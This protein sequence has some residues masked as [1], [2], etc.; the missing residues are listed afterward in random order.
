MQG[1]LLAVLLFVHKQN[2][3]ANTFL[4]LLVG[5]LSLDLLQEVFY[6]NRLY[7]TYPHLMGI[8]Y[9][10]PFLYGPL[11]YL[12]VLLL[13]SEKQK[14]DARDLLHFLP[15]FAVLVWTSW[16]YFL[17]GPEKLAFIHQMQARP[18]FTFIVIGHLIPIQGF[19]Y[20][21]L[22]IRG[23]ARHNRR[24]RDV[25]SNIDRI[26]LRWLRILTLSV[27]ITWT[28][29][30]VGTVTNDI[31]NVRITG[32]SIALFFCISLLIYTIGYMGLSQ[33]E[34]FRQ[35][36]ETSP[37]EETAE[38]VTGRYAKSGLSD[39]SANEILGGLQRLMETDKPYLHGDLTLNKLAGLLSVTPHNLSEAM[40]TRLKQSFYDYVNSFRI[41]EVKR[42]LLEG[43][44]EKFNILS[45]AFDAGFTSKTTFNTIF[46]KQTGTT[47][48]QFIVQHE[49]ASLTPPEARTQQEGKE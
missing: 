30:I 15:A 39:A 16:V 40:N 1:F 43:D 12:Y 20:T 24:I 4:G 11:F 31:A 37:E 42:R 41:H 36:R 35:S 19:V 17:S 10:F 8:T 46:R 27:A 9:V 33:P 49:A 6:L 29:V 2:R 13:T 7:E 3:T 48:S 21:V 14:P 28:V 38:D 18:P 23:I 22:T 25:Y 44:A 45:I 47:P 32:F 5:A 26:N 34:V